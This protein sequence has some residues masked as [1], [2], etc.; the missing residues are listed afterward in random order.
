MRL[1]LIHPE[2]KYFAGAETMLLYFL[3][4]LMSARSEVVV[5]LRDEGTL[6]RRIRAGPSRSKFVIMAL[7]SIDCLEDS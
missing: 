7:F 2:A 4:G 5:A 1:L 6:S 3:E